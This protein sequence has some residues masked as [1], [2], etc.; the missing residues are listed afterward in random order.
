M[1][2][3]IHDL[4]AWAYVEHCRWYYQY[5]IDKEKRELQ[6]RQL[7]IKKLEEELRVLKGL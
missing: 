2:K 7:E 6:R 3:P 1:P 4:E 5:Q